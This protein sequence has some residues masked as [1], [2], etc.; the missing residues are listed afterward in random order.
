MTVHRGGGA[1][2]G[3]PTYRCSSGKHVSRKSE[4]V[5]EYISQI[6]VGRLTQ[7]DAASLWSAELPDAGVLMFEADMLRRRRD[8]IAT[9]YADLKMDR[10]QF[11]IASE[12]VLERL[13]DVEGRIA[14][15]G[16]TSPLAIVAAD[17]IEATWDGLST[18][19]KRNIIDVLM[20]PVLHLSGAGTREFRPETVEVRWKQ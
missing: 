20:V 12:R 1:H 15:V 10:Q 9:D 4:P 5:D 19:Q 16:S 13:A 3:V 11:R 7:E 8:D 2:P 14:A 17:N 6:V 18:A